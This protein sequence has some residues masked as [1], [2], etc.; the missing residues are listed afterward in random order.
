MD[1][2]IS[3]KNKKKTNS[4]ELP[5]TEAWILYQEDGDLLK[6]LNVH[7]CSIEV[8]TITEQGKNLEPDVE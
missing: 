7:M 6:K 5:S 1:G 8:L 4:P 2:N 3:W